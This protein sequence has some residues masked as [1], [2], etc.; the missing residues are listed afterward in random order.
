DVQT[1][2]QDKA[3]G[4]KSAITI[5]GVSLK[6]FFTG[7]VCFLVFIL[8]LIFGIKVLRRVVKKHR[9]QYLHSEL[10]YFRYFKKVAKR[11]D[12]VKAVEAL[13][14]WIDQLD[15]KEPTLQYFA[16]TYGTTKLDREVKLLEQHINSN[17]TTALSFNFKA[18][19]EA[20]KSCLE[21]KIEG[22]GQ[23]LWMNP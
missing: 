14:R 15:L 22:S 9:E 20:R 18:W 13:Y 2:G 4:D 5:L 1:A 10:Y 21:G 12:T 3:T 17:N 23:T 19:S 7:I 11:E 6:W 16:T 8:L